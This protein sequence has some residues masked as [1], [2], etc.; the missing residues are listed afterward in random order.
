MTAVTIS[1]PGVPFQ[2]LAAVNTIAA[3][4]L[5]ASLG[6]TQ[7]ENIQVNGGETLADGG[8]GLYTWDAA[9]T[10]DDDG[11]S[12]IKPADRLGSVAGR[13]RIAIGGSGGGQGGGNVAQTLA[14]LKA[15][16]TSNVSM[17]Y[18]GFVYTWTEGNF[19]DREND[20]TVVKSDNYAITAGAW[21]QQIGPISPRQFGGVG[22]G[23]ADD[24]EALQDAITAANL[25]RRPL[26]L[27]DGR[28]VATDPLFD[29]AI[30]YNRLKIY[31][32]GMNTSEIVNKCIGKTCFNLDNSYWVELRDFKITG[33]GL[34]GAAGNGHAISMRDPAIDSGTYLP[35]F[36]KLTRIY[37]TGHL[38][39]DKDAF[40][41]DMGACGVFAVNC[42]GAVLSGVYPQ[43]CQY[44]F[45]FTKTFQS[46]F[47]DCTF[48]GNKLSGLVDVLNE[49][50]TVEGSDCLGNDANAGGGQFTADIA[51]LT[52]T[53]TAIEPGT[54]LKVG[55]VL[56]GSDIA[57]TKIT[58]LGTGTG[59][60]GTYTV[61][62]PQSFTGRVMTAT[63]VIDIPLGGGFK[64]KTRAGSIVHYGSWMSTYRGNK[65]KDFY[66]CGVSVG[67]TDESPVIDG[68]WFAIPPR[69]GVASVYSRAPARIICNTFDRFG[70]FT[71]MNRRDVH[72][73]LGV[74]VN[75]FGLVDGNAHRLNGGGDMMAFVDIDGQVGNQISGTVSDNLIGQ[76][77]PIANALTATYGFRFK[78]SSTNSKM[79][80]ISGNRIRV[81]DDA[82]GLV[83][84]T[85]GFDF[86]GIDT[87]NGYP[88]N[89]DDNL[90]VNEGGV[91][92]TPK[93]FPGF[94]YKYMQRDMAGQKF[95]GRATSVALTDFAEASSAISGDKVLSTSGWTLLG[96][97]SFQGGIDRT[98]SYPRAVL[99]TPTN[100]VVLVANWTAS[101]QVCEVWA[102][103][104]SGTPTITSGTTLRVAMLATD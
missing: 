64:A 75:D 38:G 49:R 92:T 69:A 22:D 57:G 60:T 41:D 78:G 5:R 13:W 97:V 59:G 20:T 61:D 48:D 51:T 103:A 87:T 37:I 50:L 15:A 31:G 84:I 24:T 27:A 73:L 30:Q 95:R 3:L 86:S 17:V 16:P 88:F 99:S 8:G 96:T 43:N 98:R 4:R 77:A 83:T 26:N 76:G 79:L 74:G 100:N 82:P 23:T 12:V 62:Q 46:K 21:V 19:S 70:P 85:T 33:N 81:P 91:V 44:G 34:T 11:A 35:G 71:G 102:Q 2:N 52:M 90:V 53:V 7:G 58:A 36:T 93:A 56:D 66:Q 18:N 45:H 28:W 67:S 10:L 89:D 32:D 101:D 72:C 40:G 6:L 39:V 55:S 1:L 65:L 47:V 80:K 104:T 63:G 94:P 25:T 9:S 68:N 42:L 29:P 54:V 14:D